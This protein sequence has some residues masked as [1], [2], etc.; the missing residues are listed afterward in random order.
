ML[1]LLGADF[2]HAVLN[3]GVPQGRGGLHGYLALGGQGENAAGGDQ[4]GGFAGQRLMISPEMYRRFIVPEVRKLSRR[5]HGAGARAVNASDG[6]L[7]PVMDDFLA[8]CEVDAYLEIDLHAGMDLGRL[9]EAYGDR[10]T[11]IGNLDCGNTL[12]F[13]T[14]GE[15]GDHVVGCLE[16]GWGNGGHVLCASNAITAS[17]P[18]ANYLAVVNGYRGFFGLAPF[19]P[20]GDP[21]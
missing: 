19:T 17:V 18:L 6:D 5:L 8:G 14:P 16:A 3:V 21:L 10:Y 1:N 9:K 13:G 20:G 15:V 7:W 11:L 2:L 4:V 12:S